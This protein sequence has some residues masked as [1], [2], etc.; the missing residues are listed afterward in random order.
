MA[1]RAK[2]LTRRAFIAWWFASYV[3][4]IYVLRVM[5]G[6][7]AFEAPRRERVQYIM[8]SSG[9]RVYAHTLL[10]IAL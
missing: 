2:V 8:Y 3:R 10:F 7:K 6:E 5:G 4:C 1:R 9:I